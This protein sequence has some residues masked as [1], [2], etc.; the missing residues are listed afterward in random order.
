MSVKKQFCQNYLLSQ[1]TFRWDTSGSKILTNITYAA[2]NN[3]YYL[4]QTLTTRWR[5]VQLRNNGPDFL[6]NFLQLKSDCF[7]ELSKQLSSIFMDNLEDNPD[8]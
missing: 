4:I 6:N 8:Q 1:M 5:S 7:G 2:V 3:I